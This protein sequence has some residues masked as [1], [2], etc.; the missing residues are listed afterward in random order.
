M[1]KDILTKL[2]IIEALQSNESKIYEKFQ[3][4][5]EQNIRDL[6]PEINQPELLNEMMSAKKK[7]MQEIQTVEEELSPMRKEIAALSASG[8]LQEVDPS[9]IDRIKN[10]DLTI[11][12]IISQISRSEQE[13]TTKIKS[14]MERI[15]NR[16]QEIGQN[17][18]LKKKYPVKK[19]FS[20]FNQ[21]VN[22]PPPSSFDSAG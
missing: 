20:F 9:I 12:D 1:N 16:L 13:L 4:T 14:Q 22:D 18:D 3:I 5:L 6:M 10:T 7:M 19:K 2:H 17:R 8:N 21:N 11:I 15:K